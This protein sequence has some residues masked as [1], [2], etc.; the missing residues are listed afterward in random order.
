MLAFFEDSNGSKCF[1]Q[2]FVDHVWTHLENDECS[3][4]LV[5]RGYLATFITALNVTFLMGPY[6]CLEFKEDADKTWH[7]H[8]KCHSMYLLLWQM[9]LEIQQ[10]K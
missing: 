8:Q 9:E 6:K 3:T 5:W 1:N 4:E 2:K 10:Q 7:L